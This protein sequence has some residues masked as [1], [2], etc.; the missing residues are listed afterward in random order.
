M[1][2]TVAF[3][4]ALS[5]RHLPAVSLKTWPSVTAQY[6]KAWQF[7][8]LCPWV[9]DQFIITFSEDTLFVLDP[10][11]GNIVGVLSLEHPITSLATSGVYVYV[12][13][14]KAQKS[15][16]R[17]AI[18]PSFSRGKVLAPSRLS[19]HISDFKVGGSR[20]TTPFSGSRERLDEVD[21]H[22]AVVNGEEDTPDS[23]PI[24]ITV[25]E[26]EHREGEE[27]ER[28]ESQEKEG[29]GK[30]ST[31]DSSKVEGD[32]E[33]QPESASDL[34]QDQDEESPSKE[35][36]TLESQVAQDDE[37][38]QDAKPQSSTNIETTTT[39]SE[40]APKSAL[41]IPLPLTIVK[42]DLKEIKDRL[43]PTFGKLAG[44]LHSS[45]QSQ[46][47][48][49]SQTTSSTTEKENGD[50]ATPVEQ[51][52]TPAAQERQPSP[53]P[54]LSAP[55]LDREEQ[56]RRLRMAQMD[57]DEVVAVVT[58]SPRPHLHK[59]KKRRKHKKLSS[60]TSEF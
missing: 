5:T 55:R 59:K 31:P 32:K 26:T 47:T 14:I 49:Q 23:G 44:L 12:L 16:L 19:F 29:E 56:E 30:E 35:T 46:S 43:M 52:V 18:H 40:D 17:L 33:E 51:L 37:E 53:S 57:N 3:K 11:G 13:C 8:Q 2:H 1:T 7:T 21:E 25:N 41:N 27:R 10:V 36:A 20:D 58:Q 39:P 9:A 28:E 15:I 6:N 45:T 60:A 54:L 22:K 42:E 38:A 4:E 34:K 50:A 48:S 24:V